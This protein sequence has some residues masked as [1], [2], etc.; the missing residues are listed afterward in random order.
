MD[1]GRI[2]DRLGMSILGDI[3]NFTGQSPDQPD[4]VGSTKSLPAL[5]CSLDLWQQLFGMLGELRHGDRREGGAG[6]EVTNG[7]QSESFWR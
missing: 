6:M 4:L 2:Q 3:Q 7:F 5:N 1:S